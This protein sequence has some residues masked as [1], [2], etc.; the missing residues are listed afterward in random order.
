MIVFNS[1]IPA[2][3]SWFFPVAAITIGPV[4]FVRGRQASPALLRH[5]L[6]HVAQGRELFFV[7]FWLLYLGFWLFYLLQC[8]SPL[9]AYKLIP[10][11]L[12]AHAHQNTGYYLQN[13]KLFAWRR[14]II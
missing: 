9:Q 14:F 4:I 10:F 6:I 13:R 11:E 3:V 5:E 8:G 7:G 2:L 12:E 1:R